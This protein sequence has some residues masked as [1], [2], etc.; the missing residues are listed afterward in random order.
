MRAAYS[1]R[2]SSSDLTIPLLTSFRLHSASENSFTE[3]VFQDLHRIAPRGSRS[4]CAGLRVCK[5]DVTAETSPKSS[6][7]ANSSCGSLEANLTV[8]ISPLI[9]VTSLR[10]P[11][12][13]RQLSGKSGQSCEV[14]FMCPGCAGGDNPS[15]LHVSAQP[16]VASETV[17]YDHLLC[18][19]P[20]ASGEYDFG[21]GLESPPCWHLSRKHADPPQHWQQVGL[22][23]P[24][25]VAVQAP[26]NPPFAPST[27]LV[28]AQPG[29]GG[30]G[31]GAGGVGTRDSWGGS[32]LG[33]DLPT[34]KEICSAL[35]RFVV[36][37]ERA[38]KVQP[39]CSPVRNLQFC[40]FL[41]K[42]IMNDGFA[43]Q[44]LAAGR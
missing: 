25:A 10:S 16:V 22:T 36:G 37:Q 33:K 28:R 20:L 18:N 4:V 15:S 30:S 32:A 39:S 44:Q 19:C 1:T 29:T 7:Q 6:M 34:P 40:F 14:V 27:N 24:P 21:K 3:G 2:A 5:Q 12:M 31:G 13:S 9:P 26:P 23:L 43:L 35:D 17:V 8:S 38:K 11:D 42:S 41:E